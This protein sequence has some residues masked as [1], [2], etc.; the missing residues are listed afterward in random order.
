[1]QSVRIV[2][3]IVYEEFPSWFLII[4][5]AKA[6][7]I[8]SSTSHWNSC[9]WKSYKLCEW[10]P[11]SWRIQHAYVSA[12]KNGGRKGVYSVHWSKKDCS[13]WSWL[14]DFCSVQLH[15]YACSMNPVFMISNCTFIWCFMLNCIKDHK[16]VS[17]PSS[18]CMAVVIC[19]MVL[20]ASGVLGMRL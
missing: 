6:T 3:T 2:A 8:S 11:V 1:M 5:C 15:D 7:S 16:V 13:P 19:S 17:W 12:L 20:Q 14:H 9:C 18:V 4:P 10:P